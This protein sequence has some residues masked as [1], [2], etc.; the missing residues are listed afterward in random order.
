MQKNVL[1]V[2]LLL[3]ASA[4]FAQ[5]K[6]PENQLSINGFRNPSIGLEYQ[7]NQF[8][9]H[10]GYYPTNFESG[11]TTEFLKAGITYWFLP[12][13]EKEIPSSFYGGL[14]YLRGTTRVYKDENALGVEAGF[15]WY[16][17]K[18][19]NFRIGVIALTAEGKDLKINPTPSIS[20]SFKF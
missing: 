6:F 10:A 17:W 18:G 5:S 16:V 12:V 7:R 9:I 14:S 1:L 13:D 19:L 4:T 15:R 3:I 20:Y 11:V 8:S 2:V